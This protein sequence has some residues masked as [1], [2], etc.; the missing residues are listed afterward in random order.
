MSGLSVRSAAT[1]FAL[2]AAVVVGAVAIGAAQEKAHTNDPRVGLK[3]GV[4][5][6][7]IAVKGLELVAT[8]FK[9][10]G[11]YDPKNP[12]GDPIPAEGANI[13]LPAPA[14]PAA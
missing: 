3:A 12:L 7:G 6:A 14:A 9:P 8:Q 10:D 1:N 5:D 2:A 4:K 13:T 11:F